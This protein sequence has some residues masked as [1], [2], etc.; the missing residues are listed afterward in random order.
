VFLAPPT[1]NQTPEWIG[2]QSEI[3]VDRARPHELKVSQIIRDND[4]A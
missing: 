2:E 3:I 4:G 1:L